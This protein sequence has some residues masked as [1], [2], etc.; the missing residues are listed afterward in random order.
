MPASRPVRAGGVAVLACCG[1]LLA[2]VRCTNYDPAPHNVT[3]MSGPQR[4]ASASFGEGA[5]FEVKL[6]KPGIVHY[7]ST[8][9]PATMNGTIEV[10]R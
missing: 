8:T 6:T 9:Q 7:E 10:L 2:T 1:P 4:F 3:S 5:T